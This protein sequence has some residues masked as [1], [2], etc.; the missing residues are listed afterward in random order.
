MS[1]LLEKGILASKATDTDGVEHVLFC[2]GP[3]SI[4]SKN[5]YASHNSAL[6]SEIIPLGKDARCLLIPTETLFELKLKNPELCKAMDADTESIQNYLTM[7]SV[8]FHSGEGLGRVAAF[9]Y[10]FHDHR[11]L[12]D[13]SQRRVANFT[14]L[15]LSQVWR[16]V[17]ELRKEE[18]IQTGMGGIMITDLK[19][20]KQ[21]VPDSVIYCNLTKIT[22]K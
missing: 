13:F 4:L 11:M 15:S 3:G 5:T 21:F 12:V 2:L 8:A 14:N 16:S 10:C 17:S 6:F 1:F 9:L 20:L 22:K 7:A 19:R 18:A